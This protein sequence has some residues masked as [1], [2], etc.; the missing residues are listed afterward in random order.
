MA[1]VKNKISSS[2][3]KTMY[4]E[5]FQ[6]AKYENNIKIPKWNFYVLVLFNMPNAKNKISSNSNDNFNWDIFRITKYISIYMF[7]Y[8]SLIK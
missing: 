7:I 4:Y 8:S 5:V 6:I 2:F 1:N 3:N